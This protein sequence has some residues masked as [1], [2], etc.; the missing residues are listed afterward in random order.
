MSDSK[1][2]H[3][4]M[5]PDHVARV[6]EWDRSMVPAATQM[7]AELDPGALD[8]RARDMLDLLRRLLESPER[9]VA[10]TVT[11]LRRHL[12]AHPPAVEEQACCEAPAVEGMSD[13]LAEIIDPARP[14]PPDAAAE[15]DEEVRRVR[16]E[17]ADEALEQVNEELAAAAHDADAEPDLV[18]GGGI[19]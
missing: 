13:A 10:W 17:R 19:W 5:D 8:D 9:R 16:A 18:P 15:V 12:D 7:V 11:T 1:L 4:G 14:L 2:L 6:R 3:G